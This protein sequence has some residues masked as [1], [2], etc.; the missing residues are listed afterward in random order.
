MSLTIKVYPLGP[1]S[2]N[3]YLVIDDESGD[4]A[5]ID[6]G[7]FGDLII[8]DIVNPDKLKYVLLTHGH[9]DHFFSINEYLENFKSAKFIAPENDKC[10]MSKDWN[11]DFLTSGYFVK[12]CPEADIY[13][14]EG[15]E[16]LFG[17]HS[18]TFLDTPGHTEGGISIIID[19]LVFTGDTLF[20]LSVG[21]TSFD[22]GDWN[23][24]VSSIKNKLY[25]LDDDYIVY[26]GHGPLTTI[27]EEKRANPFV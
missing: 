22:T 10:L 21:N 16:I 8:K 18:F 24:L 15:S 23:E 12:D 20:R 3:T 19:K 5:V 17:K 1:L 26:P 9:F 2:E 13:V 25:L 4:M 6:P 14:K 11:Q 7:Y 27:G